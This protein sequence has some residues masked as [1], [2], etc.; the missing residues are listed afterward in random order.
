[1]KQNKFIMDKFNM[2][3][4]LASEIAELEKL[5]AIEAQALS[6]QMRQKEIVEL[7]KQLHVA[8]GVI[9]RY[10]ALAGGA[11]VETD[12]AAGGGDG[13]WREREVWEI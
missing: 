12:A 3:G 1:M 2:G 4:T 10:E 8:M 5:W 6:S 13:R 9:R 7:K 11:T